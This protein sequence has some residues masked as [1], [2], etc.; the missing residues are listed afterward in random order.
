M[1][2]PDER[3][4]LYD[5]GGVSRPWH[6]QD[7]LHREI[8]RVRRYGGTT[9]LLLIGIDGALA[10]RRRFG[11]ERIRL[12]ADRIGEYVCRET[13]EADVVGH[14]RE[15]EITVL[16]PETP[17]KS[18]YLLAERLRRR[19]EREVV[20]GAQGLPVRVSIGVS[21]YR[22]DAEFGVDALM[23]EAENALDAAQRAGGNRIEVFQ[24]VA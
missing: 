5:K 6:F 3:P 8:A 21:A 13:R 10:L 15:E 12:I 18:A 4:S 11:D 14:L 23:F 16:M 1:V 24:S 22:P 17:A 9:A 19:I 2:R 20:R 7:C